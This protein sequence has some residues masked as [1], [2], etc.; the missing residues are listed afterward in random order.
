[1]LTLTVTNISGSFGFLMSV[2]TTD[3][4]GVEHVGPAFGFLTMIQG[5]A[6]GIG[7]PISGK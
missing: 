1:M 2:L 6:A 5:I 3:F 4:V 7:A